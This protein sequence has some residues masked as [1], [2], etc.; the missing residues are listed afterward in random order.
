M[1]YPALVTI[2]AEIQMVGLALSSNKDGVAY[3]HGRN[4]PSA[5]PAFD[6]KAA[7]NQSS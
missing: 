4:L 2:V 1:T 7:T 3:L 6:W 5:R